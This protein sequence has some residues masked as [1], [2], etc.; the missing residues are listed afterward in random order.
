ME[1]RQAILWTALLL[2]GQTTDVIT[3][4]LDRARGTLESMPVSAR[5]LDLGGIGLFWSTKLLLVAAA[6]AAL[7][8]TARWAGRD[9][10]RSRTTF[11]F[12]LVAVQAATVGLVWVSL[13]NVA[14]LGSLLQ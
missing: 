11:R 6:G 13:T 5:L 12:C 2:A 3:T 1:V 9:G 7:V 4:A 8:L 14:L 10:R